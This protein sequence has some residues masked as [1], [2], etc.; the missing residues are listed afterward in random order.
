VWGERGNDT[1]VVDE[2]S[3]GAAVEDKLRG[4]WLQGHVGEVLS[5]GGGVPRLRRGR[6]RGVGD[7][8]TEAGVVSGVGRRR[9][10]G[11][12]MLGVVRSRTVRGGVAGMGGTPRRH[13]RGDLGEARGCRGR[14][15]AT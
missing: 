3:S 10:G 13:G 11:G 4:R 6:E 2:V 14:Q 7:S 1:G 12:T 8:V 5:E 9:E 15:A